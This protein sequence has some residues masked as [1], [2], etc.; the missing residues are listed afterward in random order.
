MYCTQRVKDK[1]LLKIIEELSKKYN[2]SKYQIDSIVYSRIDLANIVMRKV[3]KDLEIYPNVSLK[4]LGKLVVTN[5]SRA[6]IKKKK[7]YYAT[8]K[9]EQNRRTVEE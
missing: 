1:T 5:R 7:L 3:D 8:R 2:L 4:G 9:E 6:L